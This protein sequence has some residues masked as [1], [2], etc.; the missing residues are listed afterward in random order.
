MVNTLDA[1]ITNRKGQTLIMTD[2]VIPAGRI[3]MG[4]E[5]EKKLNTRVDV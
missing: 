4:M 1:I 2:V 5:A 3:V